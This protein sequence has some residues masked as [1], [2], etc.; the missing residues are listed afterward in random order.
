MRSS[1]TY[2]FLCICIV[3]VDVL[4]HEA[5]TVICKTISSETVSDECR[6]LVM[7]RLLSIF[8]N[9]A[10]EAPPRADY[11]EPSIQ[12]LVAL[13]TECLQSASRLE[14]SQSGQENRC[15]K[16]QLLDS[17][18]EKVSMSL[19]K[20]LSPP[21]NGS[22]LLTIQHA[23][24]LVDLVTMASANVP[25]RHREDFCAILLTGALKCLEVVRIQ[26]KENSS[27]SDADRRRHRDEILKLFTACFSGVCSVQPEDPRLRVIAEQIVSEALEEMSNLEAGSSID[28][29]IGIRA[30]LLVCQSMQEMKE[31]ETL[32][33][34]L[35][36][37]LCKLVGADQIE[38]RRTVGAFLA[39][40]DVSRVLDE[41]KSRCH[42]AEQRA[43]EAEKRASRLA[44]EV[45]ELKKTKEALER[46]QAVVF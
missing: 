26:N 40:V 44:K 28:S 23:V 35:F 43:D 32:A 3:G 41:T 9:D 8:M 33:I 6:V 24:E 20:M 36:P 42:H 17:L 19:S 18:W 14:T 13:A 10:N 4:S 25:R 22:T 11:V 15:V 2:T 34:H 30:T 38:L 45:E 37:K 5:A 39:G 31:V 21:Q 46:Q 16:L 27:I 12:L 1:E 29:L 7:G